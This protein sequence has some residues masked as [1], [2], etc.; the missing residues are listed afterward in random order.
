M[1]VHVCV[2]CMQVVCRRPGSTKMTT[3]RVGAW[4]P[5]ELVKSM[6]MA[7]ASENN[8]TET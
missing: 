3:P 8:Q 1:C 7:N 6:Q 5:E 4:G 2:K